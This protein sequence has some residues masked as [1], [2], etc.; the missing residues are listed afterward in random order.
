MHNTS[1]NEVT[2]ITP[3]EVIFAQKPNIPENTAFLMQEEAKGKVDN[4]SRIEGNGQMMGKNQAA[5]EKLKSILIDVCRE[6]IITHQDRLYASQETKAKPYAVGNLVRLRL[7]TVQKNALGGKKIAPRN[8][9]WLSRLWNI[10][11]GPMT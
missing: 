4:V 3:H 11:H 1:I 7:N 9:S 5:R 6:N 2:G 10:V 8:L